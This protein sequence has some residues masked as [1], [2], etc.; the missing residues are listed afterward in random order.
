MKWVR[1]HK[2]KEG[3]KWCD[4]MKKEKSGRDKNKNVMEIV[5]GNRRHESDF[6]EMYLKDIARF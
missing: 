2:E 1:L 4:C 6:S 3:M 5:N